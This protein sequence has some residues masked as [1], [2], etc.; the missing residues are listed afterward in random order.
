M[1][2]LLKPLENKIAENSEQVAD[3]DY[4]L[5]YIESLHIP[6][7]TVIP[8]YNVYFELGNHRLESQQKDKLQNLV[9]FLQQYP[10]FAL[11][12]IGYADTL[13]QK[14][15]NRKLAEKRNR[16]VLRTLRQYGLPKRTVVSIAVGE[17]SGIDEMSNPD[18]RRVEVKPYVHGWYASV[19]ATNLDEVATD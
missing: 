9:H 5:A 18:N 13:G 10:M 4:R 14:F 11:E 6:E 19:L 12:L 16:A 7:G 17:A 8:E 2:N 3:M 15:Y 1:Q